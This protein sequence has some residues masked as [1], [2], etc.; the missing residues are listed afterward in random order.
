MKEVRM[1][2]VIAN[3]AGTHGPSLGC[4]TLQK[5]AVIVTLVMSMMLAGCGT[6]GGA[7]VQANPTAVAAAASDGPASASARRSLVMIVRHGEKPDASH[8]GVDAGGNRDDSSL[9]AIGWNRAYT[10]VNLFA[11]AQGPPRVGFARPTAIYAASA[12]ANGEGRRT[13]ETVQPL[14]DALGIPVN[15]A[16]G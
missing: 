1:R 4:R 9:S 6:S 5:L 7:K 8:P 3:V 10:L 15:T 2:T 13:R 11:P 14:A 12:N 16:F